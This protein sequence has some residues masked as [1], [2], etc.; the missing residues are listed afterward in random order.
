MTTASL[1]PEWVPVASAEGAFDA[2]LVRPPGGRSGPGLLLLQEIFGVNAHI[3]AVAQQYAL[4]G[5]TVL[6]PD[7]FWRQQPRVALRYDGADRERA[8][9]LMRSV[10]RE[11]VV[12]DMAASLGV[13]RAQ[14]SCGPKVAALGYCMG[15]R[16]A[17]A[18]AALCGVD[19]AVAYYGGGIAD[20]LD[21]A[22]KIRCPMQFHHAGRDAHIPATAV[23]SIEAAMALTPEGAECHLYP[24]A[25]HGF[26]CWDRASHHAPSAVLALSRSLGFLARLF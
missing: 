17:F 15:G 21:L 9:A 13:L 14:P 22:H 3:Q 11:Q 5:F 16:L 23:A 4:A 12:A 24:E 19:A 18:A 10:Q 7:L 20:Q 2:Y 6:A 25:D 8:M 26:N 1:S